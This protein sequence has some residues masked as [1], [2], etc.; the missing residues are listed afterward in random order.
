MAVT[1]ATSLTKNGLADWV[2]QRFTAVVI[3]VYFVV[4]LGWIV[5]NSGFDYDAWKGFMGSTAMLIATTVTL[6]CIA[7][8]TWIG[9]W[10][11]TTDYLT[12][13]Q[14]GGLGTPSRII[15]QAVIAL[16]TLIYLV[17]GL[18]IIWGGA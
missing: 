1:S 18:V 10:G 16:V 13:R 14:M 15:A 4:V 2:V 17:W 3:A 12:T 11:V 9:L 5:G 8:H 7:A 6:F